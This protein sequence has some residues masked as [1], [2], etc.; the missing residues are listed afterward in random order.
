[1]ST[2][3]KTPLG[4]F[5]SINEACVAHDM[6]RAQITYRLDQVRYKDWERKE[7]NKNTRSA[8]VAKKLQDAKYKS[9]LKSVPEKHIILH[10]HPP[11]MRQ[12]ILEVMMQNELTKDERRFAEHLIKELPIG[13]NMHNRKFKKKDY[14]RL[15][16]LLAKNYRI[17]LD[18]QQSDLV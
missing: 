12:D 10:Y 17:E 18:E 15:V 6:T 9:I 3:I 4:E 7:N 14:N 13:K 11:T 8:P 2:T 5:T 1:M 16:K